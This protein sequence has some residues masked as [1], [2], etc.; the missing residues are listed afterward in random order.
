LATP[1][2]TN[3]TAPTRTTSE[4]SSTE[5]GLQWLGD[6][7]F[8]TKA[9]LGAVS[10]MLLFLTGNTMMQSVRERTPEFGILKTY[11]F[12][13]AVVSGL[14]LE[15]LRDLAAFFGEEIF[16][17]D[18]WESG[19]VNPGRL[20]FGPD[21]TL[22]V[23]VGDRDSRCCDGGEDNSLR[24]RAQSLDSDYGKT[25]RIRDDGSIPPD[26][27]FYGSVTDKQEIW[28]FG[29]RNPFRCAFDDLVNDWHRTP[30]P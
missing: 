27:P 15:H 18:A 24:M 7:N 29:L 1:L 5:S 14:V 20:L 21:N 25:L 26:N 2:F 13:N 12:P 30:L 3:S 16:V 23:T 17:A 19:S 22:Y 6:V 9:V 11:G 4:K 10:F 8:F 28:A